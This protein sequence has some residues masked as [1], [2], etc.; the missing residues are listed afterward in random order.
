MRGVGASDKTNRSLPS[1]L[2]TRADE[3]LSPRFLQLPF[4][5]TP[6]TRAQAAEVFVS[7]MGTPFA[8]RCT[9]R[10]TVVSPLSA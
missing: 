10:G 8:K 5:A 7:S 9:K 4:E 1:L 6:A 2:R 3:I